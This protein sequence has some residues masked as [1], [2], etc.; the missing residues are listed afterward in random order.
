MSA[1]GEPGLTL[2]VA[3]GLS[4]VDAAAWD[5]LVPPDD[6]FCEHAFLRALEDSGSAGPATGFAPT[7]LLLE[8]GAGQLRGAVPTWLKSHS[9]GEYIFDWGIA[10]A[11][12][13]MGLRYYPKLAAAVPFTPASGERLLGGAAVHRALASG[14]ISLADATQASSVHV[15]FC[16]AAE[17]DALAEAG[18]VPRL[19]YQFTWERP[20]ELGPAGERPRALPGR[21][22]TDFGR[23]L[24]TFRAPDRK[25]VNRE[26]REA[27]QLGLE[28]VTLT[29]PELTDE[30]WAAL[31][32]FY[33]QTVDGKGGHAYL[34]P[35]FF[36]RLRGE[37]AHR[38]VANLALRDGRAVAGAL[39]FERGRRLYGRY[40]GADESL[41]TMHFELCYHRFIERALACGTT[42][43]EAGAQGEHKLKR[44]LL[45]RPTWSAH[46]IRDP[47]LRDAVQRGFAEEWRV[48]TAEIAALEACGPLKRG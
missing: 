48:N 1:S 13:S 33:R 6:P 26:R 41:P 24:E 45:P 3:T 22:D 9:Y 42:R 18:F 14:L 7:H 15:L 35:E 37:L 44:G 39:A 19:T 4:E 25:K 31:E 43:F 16:T 21:N 36:A 17:R 10:N 8:D 46:W 2:R 40:W 32:R 12:R 27:A 20:D 23:W 34:T 11:A 38:V 5:A 28:V 30:H 29:G 47:R